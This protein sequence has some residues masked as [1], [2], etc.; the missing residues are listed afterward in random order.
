MNRWKKLGH[1]ANQRKQGQME[2]H[3]AELYETL[4]SS[5]PVGVYVVQNRE[6]QFANPQFQKYTGFNEDELLGTDSLSIVYPEDR[7]MVRQNA[8]RMLKEERSSP[9]EFRIITKGRKIRWIMQ[10]VTSIQHRGERAVLGNCI[11]VTEHRAAMQGLEELEAL[12]HSILD[13]VPNVVLVFQGRHIIFANDAAEAMFGW[14]A[15]EL[16]GKTIEVLFRTER[17]Y[18]EISRRI[19]SMIDQQ[20]LFTEE[21]PCRRKDG[22]DI[23]CLVKSSKLGE[24]LKQ[25]RVVAVFEYITEPRK[26]DEELQK[27]RH[28][29][30]RRVKELNCLYT[31]SNLTQ[32]QNISLEEICSGI[33]ALIP[34]ACEYA[35][36][37]CARLVLEGK[38]FRTRNYEETIWKQARDIAVDGKRI[39]TLEICHLEE[40]PGNSLGTLQG[41][42]ANL[43]NSIAAQLG[44]VIKAKRAQEM[45]R[46]TESKLRRIITNSADGMIVV[47]ENGIVRF[48]NPAAEA[49]FGRKAGQLL[50][51]S[52]GYP[53]LVGEKTEIDIIR[54]AGGAV[55]AEMR[56]VEIE[57]DGRSGCLA[58]LRDITKRNRTEQMKDNF[59][60]LASHDSERQWQPRPDNS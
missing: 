60:P 1:Q 36:S 53:L 7:E 31:I 22:R 35:E 34:H 59:V 15:E 47:D 2:E 14:K 58:S 26:M 24:S 48:V 54:K 57:W 25:S 20:A 44:E 21:L 40:R 4:V 29:L 5:S 19:D 51:E 56:T 42:E 52:F 33:V 16:I 18:E 50:G 23:M 43:I 55:R 13:A 37:T 3:M 17:E 12:E 11:D 9:Y 28:E 41:E 46:N 49:L 38:E 32:E 8:V 10:R 30:N 45:L 6:F 27:Q 39:G